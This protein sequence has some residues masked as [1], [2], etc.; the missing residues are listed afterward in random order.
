MKLFESLVIKGN[1]LKNRIVMAPM[2]MYSSNSDGYIGH[3]Q[4]THYI[5]R[6]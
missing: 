6:E 1:V 5:M 3:F 2:C 4:L